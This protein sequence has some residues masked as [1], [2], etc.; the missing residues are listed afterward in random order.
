MAA[1]LNRRMIR[2]KMAEASIDTQA[3][4]A[5]RIGVTRQHMSNMLAG[6]DP[7]FPVLVKLASALGCTIDEIVQVNGDAV[8]E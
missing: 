1:K 2:I 4:L 6:S 3:E 8:A 5:D 7:S